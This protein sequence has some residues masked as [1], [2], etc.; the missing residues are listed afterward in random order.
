LR[1]TIKPL[2]G[3]TGLNPADLNANWQNFE[4]SRQRPLSRHLQGF[5]G[6]NRVVRYRFTRERSLGLDLA[7]PVITK[8]MQAGGIFVARERVL[9][10]RSIDGRG[11]PPPP[12]PRPAQVPRRPPDRVQQRDDRHPGSYPVVEIAAEASCQ[13]A[14]NAA[15]SFNGTDAAVTLNPAES[16]ANWPNLSSDDIHGN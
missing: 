4:E 8:L 6:G 7:W 3:A 10:E 16:S 15:D 11:S 14:T 12:P 5:Y 2:A 13:R 1:E 9:A